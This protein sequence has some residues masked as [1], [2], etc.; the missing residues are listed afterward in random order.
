MVPGGDE[1]GQIPTGYIHRG[2][3]GY[4]TGGPPGQHG[5]MPVH[6]AMTQPRLGCSDGAQGHVRSLLASPLT[7]G[8]VSPLLPREIIVARVCFVCAPEIQERRQ[9]EPILNRRW[10]DQLRYRQHLRLGVILVKLCVCD[11]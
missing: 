2:Y 6:S 7:D 4:L 1:V 5:L 8:V 9:M 3:F 10:C 11:D